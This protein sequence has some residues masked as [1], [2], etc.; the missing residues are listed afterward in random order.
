MSIDY[1]LGITGEANADWNA[2]KQGQNKATKL[3]LKLAFEADSRDEECF[4]WIQLQSWS[5]GASNSGTFGVG[6]G[7]GS[8]KASLQDF[9][10][11][12]HPSTATPELFAQCVSGKHFENAF[13]IAKKTGGTMPI[14]YLC[15]HFRKLVIS[16]YQTGGSGGNDSPS[17]SI[18]FNFAAMQLRFVA[19]NDQGGVGKITEKAWNQVRSME[20]IDV[21]TTEKHK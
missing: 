15:F 6:S 17:D 5:F 8:G 3:P 18:S 4:N 11:T 7:G 20:T 14:H 2:I 19:Q 13:V 1:Y 9:H 12:M 21:N 10:F 16:S